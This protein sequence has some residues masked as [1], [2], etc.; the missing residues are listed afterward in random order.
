LPQELEGIRVLWRLLEA[1]DTTA[2]GFF[3]IVRE[4]LINIYSNLSPTLDSQRESINDSFV[5][6]CLACLKSINSDSLVVRSE[7]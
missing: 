3:R 7:K 2:A 6:E 1:C 4:A 5:L